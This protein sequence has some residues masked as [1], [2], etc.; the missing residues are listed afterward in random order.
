LAQVIGES[1][2]NSLSE[3][4]KKFGNAKPISDGFCLD[5]LIRN[6]PITQVFYS[7]NQ[8]NIIFQKTE[9]METFEYIP[10]LDD[11]PIPDELPK[12][13]DAIEYQDETTASEPSG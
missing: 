2:S 1:N 12:F 6:V 3:M 5:T 10:S 7:L 4:G 11:I 13:I 8:C 9:Q